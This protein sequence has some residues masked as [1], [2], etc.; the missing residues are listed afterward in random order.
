MKKPSILSSSNPEQEY[1]NNYFRESCFSS[2]GSVSLTE[3][4]NLRPDGSTVSNFFIEGKCNWLFNITDN[5]GMG[6]EV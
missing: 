5:K 1:I 4:K 2:Y 6:G 3:L